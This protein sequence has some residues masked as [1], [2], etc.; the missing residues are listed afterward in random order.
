MASRM[1]FPPGAALLCT[2][3]VVY[4]GGPRVQVTVRRVLLPLCGIALLVGAWWVVVATGLAENT[5]T[6]GAVFERMLD[7]L[8]SGELLLDIR[9]SVL[10]VLIGV[11][12]GCTA[13]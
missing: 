2:E 1:Q 4:Q 13:A 11:G 10:R 3:L 5:P 7:G 12:I 9:L 8:R 6:P